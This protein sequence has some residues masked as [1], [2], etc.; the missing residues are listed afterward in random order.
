[1]D[2]NKLCGGASE[3]SCCGNGKIHETVG[4]DLAHIALNL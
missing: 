4:L 2:S 1:M 3:H